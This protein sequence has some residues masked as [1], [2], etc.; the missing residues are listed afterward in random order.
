M[1]LN[2]S[3]GLFGNGSGMRELICPQFIWAKFYSFDLKELG[4]RSCIEALE[5]WSS[6]LGTVGQVFPLRKVR[7]EC[8]LY[9]QKTDL[10]TFRIWCNLSLF[11]IIFNNGGG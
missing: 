8:M 3:W 11:I 4:M 5:G 10:E 6:G 2:A 1:I 9:Y 7:R